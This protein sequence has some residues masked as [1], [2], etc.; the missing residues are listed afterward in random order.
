M[1]YSVR[2][3]FLSGIIFF[4][5]AANIS[6]AQVPARRFVN[7]LPLPIA[8]QKKAA[9]IKSKARPLHKKIPT[10]VFGSAHPHHLLTS[11]TTTKGSKTTITFDIDLGEPFFTKSNTILKGSE[12]KQF[13]EISWSNVA[14]DKLQPGVSYMLSGK[15]GEPEIPMLS[16]TIAIPEGAANITPF[17]GQVAGAS[18]ASSF[19]LPKAD[20]KSE[21]VFSSATYK[22]SVRSEPVLSSPVKI[23][24]MRI[25]SLSVPLAEFNVSN[26]SVRAKKKFNCGITFDLNSPVAAGAARNNADPVFAE[27][28]SKIAANTSDIERFRTGFHSHPAS[29]KLQAAVANP[30][31]D[32]SII[33]WID[34]TAQ[35]IKLVATRTG[36]YRVTAAEAGITGWKE[37]ELRMFNKGI[38]V[39]VWIDSTADGRINAIEYYGEI[40]HGY[41]SEYLNW[42][43]D[44]NAYWLTNSSKFQTPPKRYTDKIVAGN[45][46]LTISEGNILL[47]HE[48]DNFYSGGDG[49]PDDIHTLHRCEW[50]FGERFVWQF[51]PNKLYNDDVLNVFDTFMIASLPADITGKK[52]QIIALF[53]GISTSTPGSVT[54]NASIIINGNSF[55]ISFTDYQELRDT[56]FIPLS[57]L[58]TGPNAFQI[59]FKQGNGSPDKWYFDYYS[60]SLPAPLSANIDTS[61][62]KGQ[63]AFT[64]VP[65]Q[66]QFN[67]ALQT[68]G[69]VPHLFDLTDN[70]KLIPSGS[71]FK[72]SANDTAHYAGA[73][74]S[75]FLHPARIV[76]A[77]GS[78]A[79]MLDTSKGADYIII[80]HPLF[81]NTAK[82]LESRRQLA[83][84]RTKVVT[85]DDV[86]NVFNFG[87]DEPWA[88]RRYLQY[89]YDFYS[90]APP[91][92]VTLF[93]DG[94]WDPKFDLNNPFQENTGKTIHRSFVPTFGV[95]NSDYIFTTGDENASIDS[96]TFKMII[97]RIPVESAD[98]ADSYLT[99]LIEYET[100]PP[101]PWNKNFLFV[102]GGDANFSPIDPIQWTQ[103]LRYEQLY[104]GLPPYPGNQYGG[105]A[106][107]P[108]SCNTTLIFRHD[109][110]DQIDIT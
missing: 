79:N 54:H 92:F 61:I 3:R 55:D 42:D 31:F 9:V 104:I 10:R 85:T 45:P 90:G 28:Y 25:L 63:W 65:A 35:Y 73:I 18:F 47:H 102:A 40:L 26:G 110:D 70:T 15:A 103:L 60:V 34:P 66:S 38:E 57:M 99:K 24:T 109:L 89:A 101:Q 93:G 23:R 69:E 17:L 97:A 36:L 27:L 21:R 83:G 37:S 82:R 6:F 78:F 94:T 106:N 91:S 1:H 4:F 50:I 81:L 2:R 74:S 5:L 7:T 98:E 53:K 71:V 52:A 20:A 77:T 29:V 87:S 8:A 56:F 32:R 108:L 33:N 72:E 44:S 14:I 64:L 105:V 95:P 75:S 62:A 41:P 30:A 80:T 100:N 13:G 43:T 22:S 86:F 19:L 11:R 96:E 76:N 48:E 84:L 58:K 51:L 68:S 12:G 107:P 46:S 59:A 39:P 67:I 88:L 16:V 49:P